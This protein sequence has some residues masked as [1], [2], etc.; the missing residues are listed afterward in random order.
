MALSNTDNFSWQ[1]FLSAD[2]KGLRL[3]WDLKVGIPRIGNDQFQGLIKDLEISHIWVHTY[4][5]VYSKLYHIIW[6]NPDFYKCIVILICG[7]H[8]LRVKQRLVYK[9]SNCIDVKEWWTNAG[10]IALTSAAQAM[11]GHLYYRCMY[12]YKE[13]FDVLVQFWFKK[14]KSWLFFSK[15][16]RNINKL[17]ER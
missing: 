4:E 12:L 10:V 14:A 5:M 8:Q 9:R 17:F 7:F 1:C 13:C 15:F 3:T 2:F 16:W 11:E 6:K